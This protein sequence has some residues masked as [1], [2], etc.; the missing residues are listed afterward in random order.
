MG[1]DLLSHIKETGHDPVHLRAHPA[2]TYGGPCEGM[3]AGMSVME[4]HAACHLVEQGVSP[5]K[6][7]V[8]VKGWDAIWS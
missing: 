3:L 6:A 2:G 7:Q 4:V 1:M 5:I 8:A